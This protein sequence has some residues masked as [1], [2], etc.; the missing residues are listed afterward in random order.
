MMPGNVLSTMPI[1][2]PFLS[3]RTTF[4]SSA[5]AGMTDLHPGGIAIGDPSQGLNY[6]TWSATADN[7][8]NILVQA[9]NTGGPILIL[10]NVG[11]I[12]VALAFDQNARIFLAYVTNQGNAYYYWF[13]TLIS[14]YKTSLLGPGIPR[15]FAALDD[16]RPLEIASSDVILAYI[17]SVDG[18][19]YFRQQRD[20]FGIEYNLG[21]APANLVQMWMNHV[22]RLQ[23]AFQNA[24]AKGRILPPAEFLGSLN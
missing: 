18:N 5:L 23:F 19:L 11:A 6:Q 8:G 12:W 17:K 13:D 14:A 10:S 3:P 7:G 1:V 16:I 20:R 24:G 21:V 2:A 4:R 15:V 9:P 22:N